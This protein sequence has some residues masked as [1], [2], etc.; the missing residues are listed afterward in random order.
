MKQFKKSI[1]KLGKK[2]I[3]FLNF[4]IKMIIIQKISKSNILG[5]DGL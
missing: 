4:A 3:K 1:L 2:Y 5:I